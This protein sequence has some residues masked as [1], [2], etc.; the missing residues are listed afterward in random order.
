LDDDTITGAV[1][2]AA[3]TAVAVSD[4]IVR[5]WILAGFEERLSSGLREE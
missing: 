4:Q 2:I 5:G 3:R 1:G